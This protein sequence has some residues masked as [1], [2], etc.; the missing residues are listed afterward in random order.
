MK[1]KPNI[2]I[3][4]PDQMRADSMGHLG[5]PTK[6]TPFL[7]SFA[8][9]EA[10][11]FRNAFCQ[12]PV[13]VPSRCSFS[14]GLYPHT[15]GHRTMSYLLREN[16]SSIFSELREAGYHVWMNSRNDLV[17]GQIPG[18]I[19]DHADEIYYGGNSKSAPGTENENPRGAPDNKNFYSFYNGRLKLDETGRNYTGDDEDVDAAIERIKNPPEDKPLCIFLGLFYPHP[20]YQVEEPYFSAIDRSKLP[21]RIKAENCKNKSLIMQT[22][23]DKQNLKNYK[24]HDW[25]ELRACYLGMCMKVDDQFRRLVDALKE[26]GEY[27]NTAIFFFSDHGDYTGDYGISEKAQNSFEDCLVNVPLLIKPPVNYEIDPGTSDNLTELIDF[28]ATAMD[29]AGVKPSHDHFGKSLIPVLSDRKHNLREY[30]CS[31]GGRMIYEEHCDEYHDF[32]QGVSPMN[33]YWP[34]LSAQA[35]AANH[36]KGTMIRNDIYKYVHR[37][38]GSCEFYDL[39]IG[40]TVN[41][42]DDEK[43]KPEIQMMKSQLLDWFQGTA[44]IVPYDKDSRFNPEMLWAKVK[45]LCPEGYEEDIKSRIAAGAGLFDLINYCHSIK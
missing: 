37:T 33:P 11:S 13:C 45:A 30:V 10:V 16:D 14:T 5:N 23:R 29:F 27:D 40:E 9:T 36:A 38:L 41:L 25:D 7:D 17:A 15:T 28:Y 31:E 22:I 24:E 43:Y 42:I 12:N 26:S 44:D 19:E 18:L 20:P 6:A 34:R 21:E 1:K 4:N 35:D 8:A 32:A 2:V 3:I 39:E